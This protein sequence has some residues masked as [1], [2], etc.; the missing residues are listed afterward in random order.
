MPFTNYRQ[1]KLKV[2]RNERIMHKL[3]IASESAKCTLSN[4]QT[5][6][7]HLESLY[8][9]I[10][11]QYS[12]SRYI[13]SVHT[14]NNRHIQRLLLRMYRVPIMTSSAIVHYG[15]VITEGDLREYVRLC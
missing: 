5:A 13:C 2:I 1:W 4:N 9:G 7:I 8:E 12:L 15:F 3:E 14:L 6:A 11:F 10:D